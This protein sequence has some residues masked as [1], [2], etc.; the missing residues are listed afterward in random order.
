MFLINGNLVLKVSLFSL[1]LISTFAVELQ[2]EEEEEDHFFFSAS[3]SGRSL[4]EIL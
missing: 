4:G 1:A 3:M 2:E